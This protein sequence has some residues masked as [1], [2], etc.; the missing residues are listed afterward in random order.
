V[1]ATNQRVRRR[2][3]GLRRKTSVNTR[4]QIRKRHVRVLQV[5]WVMQ[6]P[7][8][9]FSTRLDAAAPNAVQGSIGMTTQNPEDLN[10]AVLI[11]FIAAALW[12]HI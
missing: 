7:K 2:I 4:W 9:L 10:A 6:N 1:E 12:P 11:G 8:L 3:H 5:C